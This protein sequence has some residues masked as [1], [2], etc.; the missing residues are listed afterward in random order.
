MGWLD[1]QDR[2]CTYKYVCE[3]QHTSLVMGKIS[4]EAGPSSECE[5]CGK[6]AA[7]AGFLPYEVTQVNKVAFDQN[8]RKAYKITDGQGGV[9]Y[10]SQTKYKYLQTGKIEP[11]YTKAYESKLREDEAGNAELL[12]T[13]THRGMAK[14]KQVMAEFNKGNKS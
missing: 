9:S 14:V 10:I 11:Q 3:D 8:G 12:G 7:Y 13:D 2:S 1:D 6:P 4:D 5:A